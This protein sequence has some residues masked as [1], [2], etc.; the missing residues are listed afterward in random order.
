MYK[1]TGGFGRRMEIPGENSNFS[2][3]DII[4]NSD[5]SRGCLGRLDPS[6]GKVTEWASPGGP[7]SKRCGITAV[8]EII[9]YSESSTKPN[10]IV[11][12][13]PKTEKFQTWVILPGGGVVRNMVHAP[14]GNLWLACSGVNRIAVVEIKPPGKRLQ[15]TDA[16]SA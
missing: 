13:D 15:K 6:T 1:W 7:K 8:G 16:N 4:W 5:Y 14:D 3:D 11:R 9:W 12:F 10:T 2:T